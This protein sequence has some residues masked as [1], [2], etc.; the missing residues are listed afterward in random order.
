MRPEAFYRDHKH[1]VAARQARRGDR[2]RRQD[3]APRQR[4][5]R[6][7]RP[8]R[9]GDRR[10][11]PGA[12]AARH[13]AR[14]VC[15]LRNLAETDELRAR[16]PRPS[17]SSSIGAGFIGL[18]FAAVARGKGKPVHIVEMVDRVMAR[19]VSAGDL[20][21]LSPRRTATPASSS[22]LA[23]RSVRIAG[24][25]GRVDACRAGRR[26]ASCRPISCWSASASSPTPRSPPKQGCAV[27][28]RRRRRRDAATADPA[29]SAIGDCASFPCRH[30]PDGR[31]TRLESVQN[32]ADHARCVADRM[33]GQ[34]ARPTPRCRGSGAS[35]ERCG[36]RSPGSP[37]G[38]T[39]PSLRGDVE[40]GEF[41]VF[42]YRGDKLLG[43]ESINRPADHAQ[44]AVCSPPAARSPRTRPPTR[45]ST[46]APPQW[47][48]PRSFQDESPVGLE[49]ANAAVLMA[50]MRPGGTGPAWRHPVDVSELS[51]IYFVTAAVLTALF[52]VLYTNLTPHREIA[53]I[54]AAIPPRR[55]RWPARCSALSC[56]SPASSPTAP[57]SSMWRSGAS[58]RW[59]CSWAG[60]WSPGWCCRICREAIDRAAIADAIF[61]AGLVAGARACSTAAC[62][63]G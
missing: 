18:E 43:I 40:S 29:I 17:T 37:P 32:A 62:M 2:P 21:V 46:C 58:S 41:S 3:G 33:I 59:P 38:S 20:A 13:R 45:A 36:C 39:G 9:A 31:M 14:G 11:Q 8:P 52:L 19:V 24:D 63:A 27:G 48:G 7:I 26:P 28:E 57:A 51:R 5:A 23:R 6:R 61:L 30:S 15:Y 55:S 34:A 35:R 56:R 49:I 50:S 54:R 12:A 22:S 1:R 4:R 44:P 47:R 25:N 10:A 42:C 53:L 16:L 60:L